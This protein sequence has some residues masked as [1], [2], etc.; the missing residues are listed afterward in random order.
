MVEVNVQH[1]DGGWRGHGRQADKRSAG[2]R[3]RGEMAWVRTLVCTVFGI[4][5]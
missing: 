5:R 4:K 1:S 2:E 3:K